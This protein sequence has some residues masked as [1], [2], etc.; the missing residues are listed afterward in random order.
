MRSKM[1][2]L[3]FSALLLVNACG[4]AV[5]LVGAAGTAG[6]AIWLSGKLNQEV[7]ASVDEASQASK[8]ALEALNFQITKETLTSDFVQLKSNYT[9]GEIIWIDIR[10]IS[11]A[12]SRIEV[13]VGVP[14][15]KDSARRVLNKIIEYL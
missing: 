6:T 4:C 7:D 10:R 8:A 9:D 3:I 11:E 5:L 15:D 2:G 12:V 14:G 13:R 1:F